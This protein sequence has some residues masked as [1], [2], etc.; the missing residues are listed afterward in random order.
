MCLG[1]SPTFVLLDKKG[2]AVP[3]NGGAN[4]RGN[5][6]DIYFGGSRP[7]AILARIMIFFQP[8]FAILLSAALPQEHTALATGLVFGVLA[9]AVCIGFVFKASRFAQRGMVICAFWEQLILLLNAFVSAGL[10]IKNGTSAQKDAGLVYAAGMFPFMLI[11][12]VYQTRMIVKLSS[13]NYDSVPQRADASD[14]ASD[15]QL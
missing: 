7:T 14:G 2:M 9:T 12:V 15:V 6:V 1:S 11:A 10:N 3:T 5:D 4:R 13:P 8:L